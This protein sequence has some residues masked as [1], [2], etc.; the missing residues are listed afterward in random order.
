MPKE[1]LQKVQE[2]LPE[3]RHSRV[4]GRKTSEHQFVGADL[5]RQA[6]PEA[7]KILASLLQEDP[8]ARHGGYDIGDTFLGSFL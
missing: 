2:K 1:F 7:A 6:P 3:V 8:E 5:F 4:A